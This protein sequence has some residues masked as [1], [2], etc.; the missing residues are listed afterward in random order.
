MPRED[1]NTR[2]ARNP[3]N[4]EIGD[5]RGDVKKVGRSGNGGRSCIYIYIYIPRDIVIFAFVQHSVERLSSFQ[6]LGDSRGGRA[7]EPRWKVKN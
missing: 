4:V 1:K 7:M 6:I 5:R 2:C 3:L